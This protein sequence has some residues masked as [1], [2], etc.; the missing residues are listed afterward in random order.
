MAWCA[1]RHGGA[2]LSVLPAGVAAGG[3]GRA[4][5]DRPQA[6]DLLRPLRIIGSV[7]GALSARANMGAAS[8]GGVSQTCDDPAGKA[9]ALATN[10][11]DARAA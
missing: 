4:P 7:C 5:A 11:T 6:A 8:E 10:C 9:T 2:S 1:D 3:A